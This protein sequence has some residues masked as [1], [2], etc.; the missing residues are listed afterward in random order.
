ML[1][2]WSYQDIE[3]GRSET[4][5]K[6]LDKIEILEKKLEIAIYGLSQIKSMGF[7]RYLM[8]N[9]WRAVSEMRGVAEKTLKEMRDV[10]RNSE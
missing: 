7:E 2:D 3:S 10:E 4:L 6:A 8:A 9:G 1:E 5:V